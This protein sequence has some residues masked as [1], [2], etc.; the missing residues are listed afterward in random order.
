MS[1]F[2]VFDSDYFSVVFLATFTMEDFGGGRRW[3]IIRKAKEEEQ[4]RMISLGIPSRGPG[5]RTTKKD[6]RGTIGRGIR[7][8]DQSEV[9]RIGPQ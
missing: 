3:R 7:K 9:Q 8:E 1:I 5:R 6:L 2:N 4:K